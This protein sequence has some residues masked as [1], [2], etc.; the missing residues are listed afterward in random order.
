MNAELRRTPAYAPA[1]PI[2]HLAL[3]ETLS[4]NF[5]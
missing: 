3:T 5:L 1:H 4:K 2:V